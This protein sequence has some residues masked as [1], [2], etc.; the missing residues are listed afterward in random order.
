MSGTPVVPQPRGKEIGRLVVAADGSRTMI[1]DGPATA[2]LA[3][4][5]HRLYLAGCPGCRKSAALAPR[6]EEA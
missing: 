3:V 2:G 1:L 4:G 6:Q 5:E